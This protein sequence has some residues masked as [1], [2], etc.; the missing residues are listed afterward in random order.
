MFMLPI[1]F[2]PNTRSSPFPSN[3]IAS[4]LTTMGAFATGAVTGKEVGCDG[5]NIKPLSESA[6]FDFDLAIAITGFAA[7]ISATA[8]SASS[9]CGFISSIDSF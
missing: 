4:S 7:T 8:S 5:F 1:C 9:P 3:A 2:V 6:S